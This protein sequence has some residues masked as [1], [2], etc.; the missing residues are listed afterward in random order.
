MVGV[1]MIPWLL[2]CVE[3][4]AEGTSVFNVIIICI[5]DFESEGMSQ[6]SS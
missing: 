5:P 3:T 4:A 2:N 6:I 1:S